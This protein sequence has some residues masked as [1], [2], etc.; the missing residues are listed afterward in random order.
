[1]ERHLLSSSCDLSQFQQFRFQLHKG[2]LRVSWENH[3]ICVI[4]G[5]AGSPELGVFAKHATIALDMVR[6][7]SCA[8]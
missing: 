3:E 2:Q 1:M 5:I 4:E 6:V 7:T 8:A